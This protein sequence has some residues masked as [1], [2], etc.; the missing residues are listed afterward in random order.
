M[1]LNSLVIFLL[2]KVA[3]ASAT[4]VIRLELN[5]VTTTN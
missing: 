2:L 1:K 5:K 3:F 4:D